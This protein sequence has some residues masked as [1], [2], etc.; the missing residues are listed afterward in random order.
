MAVMQRTQYADIFFQRFPHMYLV[1][2]ETMAEFPELFS[3]IFNVVGS[4][5][6]QEQI[7]ETTG[8]GFLQRI[9]EGETF[10]SDRVLA[11]YGKTFR[12]LQ[13]ALITEVTKVAM[14]DDIDSIFNN[15][16]RAIARA[17]RATKESYHWNL[18]NNGLAGVG[19][20]TTPDGVS[21]FNTAHPYV[22]PL[23]GTYSNSAAADLSESSLEAA[24][25]SFMDQTDDRGKPIVVN[26]VDVWVS[27]GDIFTAARI[28]DS[29]QTSD[30]T[31]AQN[32][33]NAMSKI[34]P[35]AG[36]DW[37]PYITDPDSWF[38]FADKGNHR[39]Y[40][41]MRQDAEVDPFKDDRTKNAGWTVDMRCVAGFG[42]GTGAY[43]SDGSG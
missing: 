1:F 25:T 14:Q 24:F 22:D 8:L 37:S 29:P 2:M 11:G 18:L 15:L 21:I 10:P 38:M 40:S 7:A 6:P 16:P 12:H 9:E 36:Y 28:F 19:T 39:G 35:N 4:S 30:S 43:G 32:A 31:Q 20:E 5:K 3:R 27:S 41:W 26:G 34:V 17:V 33:I 42:G 13:W 23:A